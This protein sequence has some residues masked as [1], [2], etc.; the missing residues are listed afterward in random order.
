MQRNRKWQ[1][2]TKDKN[3]WDMAAFFG[4]LSLPNDAE[5]PRLCG[6]NIPI[7]Q[8]SLAL[9]TCPL[10][11]DWYLRFRGEIRSQYTENQV[12]LLGAFQEM[13]RPATG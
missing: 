11:V 3:R 7:E 9:V 8:L 10:I 2:T 13:L 1:L 6:L 12:G 5:E 4:A